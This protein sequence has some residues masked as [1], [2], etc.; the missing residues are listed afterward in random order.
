MSQVQSELDKIKVARK[1]LEAVPD[2]AD[3]VA[4]LEAKAKILEE[5]LRDLKPKPP[6]TAVMK[7]LI[8]QI[9][10][11]HNKVTSMHAQ[12]GQLK[13]QARELQKSFRQA[14]KCYAEMVEKW[15]EASLLDLSSQG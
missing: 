13:A 14:K 6:A 9:H 1:A 2:T 7:K 11:Q 10:A 15:Q 5:Q 3:A 12:L 4:L 8:A